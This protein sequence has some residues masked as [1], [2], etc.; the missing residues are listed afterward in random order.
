MANLKNDIFSNY[1][2][3]LVPIMKEGD[4]INLSLMP[5]V[6]YMNMDD[7]GVLD[8]KLWLRIMWKDE[9]LAWNPE[10]YG[11]VKQL[12][13]PSD[14]VWMPDVV[15]FNGLS[16]SPNAPAKIFDSMRRQSP[17]IIAASGDMMQV[18]TN[19]DVKVQCTDQEFANWPWGEYN[20]KVI[21]NI[22]HQLLA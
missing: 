19:L 13:V 5:T 16:C 1:D 18:T 2:K 17:V 8:L 14:K 12:N 21:E 7:Q 22:R 3:D 9:R 6:N 10:E 11:G 4:N 15:C 20:A